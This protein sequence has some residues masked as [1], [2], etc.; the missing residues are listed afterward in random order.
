M[1][2]ARRTG[3][4]GRVG[5]SARGGAANR[6]TG[7]AQALSGR[8]QAI[9]HSPPPAGT[10]PTRGVVA[11]L[12][13][14]RTASCRYVETFRAE[15]PFCTS[16]HTQTSRDRYTPPPVAPTTSVRIA[17]NCPSSFLNSAPPPKPQLPFPSS[18]CP[19][20][21]VYFQ[22]LHLPC[23]SAPEPELKGTA[24]KWGGTS[25]PIQRGAFL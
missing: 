8:C 6:C 25:G 18:T 12:P 5:A 1:A 10:V 19:T 23:P 4:S 14:R 3:G 2:A 13:P 22:I 21:T 24:R 20:Y 15:G 11:R 16:H 7:R 17:R 9:S